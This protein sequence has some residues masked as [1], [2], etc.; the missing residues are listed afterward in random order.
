V[1]QPALRSRNSDPRY[2]HRPRFALR[3]RERD[4]PA[5]TR[6]PPRFWSVTRLVFCTEESIGVHG[7]GI[8]RRALGGARE[9][10]RPLQAVGNEADP[11]RLGAVLALVLGDLARVGSRDRSEDRRSQRC[12][13]P[14]SE[15]G[16][17]METVE[18]SQ[19]QSARMA[20]LP[21][22]YRVVGVERNAP[23]VRKPTGQII[24]I[25]QNGRLSAVTIAARRKLAKASTVS[26]WRGD[27]SWHES[28]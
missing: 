28:S 19:Q 6:W 12:S 14:T 8:A 2:G 11:D 16:E 24:R 13:A 10:G 22:D 7:S 4:E 17:H 1:A 18:L 15:S 3:L 26:D 21:E 27:A 5:V 23:L 20:E 25:Q 9:T